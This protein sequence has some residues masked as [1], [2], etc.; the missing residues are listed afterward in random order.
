MRR[1]GSGH[2][3][4]TVSIDFMMLEL[5]V[6]WLKQD[7]QR[8]EWGLRGPDFG[9][10]FSVAFL[11]K[12]GLAGERCAKAIG[13]LKGPGGTWDTK[14]VTYRGDQAE[15]FIAHDNPRTQTCHRV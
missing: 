5:A 13:S 3:L 8:E 10:R 6:E 9:K 11:G 7:F 12:G 15:V 14:F 2:L 1:I 4:A